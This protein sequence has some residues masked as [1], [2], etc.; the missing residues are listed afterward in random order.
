[1]AGGS[2]CALRGDVTGCTA[3]PCRFGGASEA[4]PRP[5]AT[6]AAT[7]TARF[8]RSRGVYDDIVGWKRVRRGGSEC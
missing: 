5:C 3:P 8:V 6:R 1:M 7:V 2:L 4:P